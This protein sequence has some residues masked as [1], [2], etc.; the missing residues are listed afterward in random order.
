MI[1]DRYIEYGGKHYP[2]FV[3]SI[4]DQS[5]EESAQNMKMIEVSVSVESLEGV[6]IDDSGNP[7]NAKATAIDEEIFFYIPDEME[8]REASEIADFV[9]DNCW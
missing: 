6:L 2:V 4:I 3:I 8:F 1:P 7:V 9:S 5:D